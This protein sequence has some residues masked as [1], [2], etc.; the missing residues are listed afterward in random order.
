MLTLM[1]RQ[2]RASVGFLAIFCGGNTGS[3][4]AG[5]VVPSPSL[6]ESPCEHEAMRDLAAPAAHVGQ[7]VAAPR[8]TKFVQPVFPSP[9]PGE[10]S[11]SIWVADVLLDARGMVRSIWV[12]LSPS[13]R[14]DF[15]IGHAIMQWE[16]APTK[17]NG[18]A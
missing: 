9:E 17:V 15:A 8:R 1:A 18:R 10:V 16:Y 4:V 2:V 7:A 6:P 14:Y 12:S 13:K 11:G 3:L 5:Q